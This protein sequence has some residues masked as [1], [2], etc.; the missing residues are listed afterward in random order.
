MDLNEGAGSGIWMLYHEPK[1]LTNDQSYNLFVTRPTLDGY[2]GCDKEHLRQTILKH[3]SLFRYQLEELHRLYKRQRDLVNEIKRRELQQ[4]LI[5][6]EISQSTLFL[7]HSDC[8]D[9]RK[10][11]HVSDLPL[12]DPTFGRPTT[13]GAN[14]IRSPLSF[15]RGK[16]VFGPFP[17]QDR[18]GSKDNEFCESKGHMLQRTLLNLEIPASVNV[19]EDGKKLGES[20]S[21]PSSRRREG[22]RERD[23]S[24]SLGSGLSPG[25]NNDVF[26][27][28]SFRKSFR[29]MVDLNE[30]TPVQE[31]SVSV[32]VDDYD[33]VTC[34]DEEIRRRDVSVNSKTGFHIVSTESHQSC[35]P[36]RN[37]GIHLNNMHSGPCRC[38]ADSFSRG[39]CPEHSPTLVISSQV[40]PSKER[41]IRHTIFGV[42]ISVG[43]HGK[44]VG[45]SHTS[46][47]D[48]INPQFHVAKSEPPSPQANASIIFHQDVLSVL[49]N[50][51]VVAPFP[52]KSSMEFHELQDKENMGTG[53]TQMKHNNPMGGVSWPRE[54][55]LAKVEPVKGK[56][57]SHHV[58]PQS[59]RNDPHRFPDICEMLKGPPQILIQDSQSSII[60]SDAELEEN[61]VPRNS[62]CVAS[63]GDGGND[64]KAKDLVTER[65]MGNFNSGLRHHIDLNLCINEEEAP[66]VPSLPRAIVKIATT[67]IDLESPAAFESEVTPS[68]QLDSA[69][70]QLQSPSRL[71]LDDSEGKNEDLESPAVFE[72]EVTPSLQLD[73]AV[74]QLESPSRLPLDDSEGK[75]EELVRVAAEAIIAISSSDPVED[76]AC[77]PLSVLSSDSL[78]WFAEVVSSHTGDFEGELNDEGSIPDGMD[79]FEFMTMNLT[80]T[81]EEEYSNKSLDFENH[82]YEETEPT[83]SSKRPRRGQARKGRQRKDFQ[84]DILPGLITLS[85]HEVTED[86]MSF[87]EL[88]RASGFSW[89]PSQSRRNTPKKGRGRRHLK[90]SAHP[91]TPTVASPPVE[92][93]VC[94]ELVLEGRTLTGWGK[95]TRRLPRQRCTTDN[96]P[97]P[98]Q[99]LKC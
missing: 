51:S 93:P 98:P 94:I 59:V 23:V 87:E 3:E 91:V 89:N 36:V 74:N 81:K 80:E 7:S 69:V 21:F 22:A 37:G 58:N 90:D 27:S 14:S 53:D 32:S 85:R 2:W 76:V 78:R 43:N 92:K 67:E 62:S 33:N 38:D 16:N 30:P 54:K 41:K 4:H 19:N 15:M 72:S 49:G 61:E 39:V 18:V 75:N 95:K 50:A 28:N 11:P 66:L 60:A 24:L 1:T 35:F 88:F 9:V 12:M 44:S 45:T 99:A 25:F 6:V 52:S 64:R 42:E 86:F 68:L 26:R 57:D 82:K 17:F 84:R 20:E 8:G 63:Y 77:H 46:S 31:V 40:E 34:L 96:P 65:T 79:H 83:F 97:P 48:Q 47:L 13:S 10:T 5:E 29:H 71:P 56:E 73:P 55:E 70:N